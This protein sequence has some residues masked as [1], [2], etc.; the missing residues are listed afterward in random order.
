MRRY[1]RLH[2]GCGPRRLPGWANVDISAEGEIVWDLR[3]P[4][5]VSTVRFVYSEHFIEHIDRPDAV[6][7]LA[8]VRRVL[9][10]DGVLRVSTPDL[11]EAVADY[12]AGKLPSMPEHGWEPQ[13]L[14][15]MLN[16][17]MR[18]WGH[19]FVYDELEL[20]AVLA[21]AGFTRVKRVA[22]GESD[23]PE[24]R[25]LESRPDFGDLIFEAR[26]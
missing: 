26:P 17:S 11:A 5:P 25:G 7:L 1:D 21:E 23:V 15:Q 2:L 13:S 12:H 19:R 9:A 3:K 10:P 22:H 18:E 20:R 4:L 16:D 6:S 24:L 8:N 14:C